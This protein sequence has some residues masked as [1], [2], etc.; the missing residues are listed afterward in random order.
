MIIYPAVD[1]KNGRCV[2]LLQGRFDRETVYGD[3]PVEIA[4]KWA[5][6]GSKWLHVVDL[7][8]AR[9]GFSKNRSILADIVK[10]VKIPVQTGGGIRTINDIDE[11]IALGAE[12]VVLGTAAVKNP[13]FLKKALDKYRSRIAVGIDAKDGKVAIDGWE[14]ISGYTAVEFAKRKGENTENAAYIH[15]MLCVF[16]HTFFYAFLG[17]RKKQAPKQSDGD[18]LRTWRRK[19]SLKEGNK[20]LIVCEDRYYAFFEIS[21]LLD[22][23]GVRQKFRMRMNC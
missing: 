17:W 1:I 9:S 5:L 7:D 20:I 11:V 6:M 13:E 10:K 2:R 14:T 19:E 4:E 23:L 8:G 12:R 16:A 18:C 21:E 3:D 22:I 15:M